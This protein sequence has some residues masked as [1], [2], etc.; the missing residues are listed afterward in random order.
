[1]SNHGGGDGGGAGEYI[2]AVGCGAG[3]EQSA[4]AHPRWQ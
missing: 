2:S 4:P 3:T 1:M